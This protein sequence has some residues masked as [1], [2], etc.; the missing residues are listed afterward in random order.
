MTHPTHAILLLTLLTAC[1]SAPP[2]VLSQMGAQ[3]E[4]RAERELVWVGT[5]TSYVHD[6]GVWRRTPAQDYTFLVHQRRVGARW[7]SLK[8]QNRHRPGYD[9][10]AGPP[11]QQHMFVLEYAPPV[12]GARA[13]RVRS[14]YGDGQGTTDTT[15][16]RATLEFRARDVSRFAPYNWFRITQHYDYAK[17]TLRERVELFYREEDGTERPFARIEER[18]RFFEAR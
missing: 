6:D 18:A 9:G 10:L 15:F 5:G 3:P 13:I 12:S 8:V 2:S 4:V 11:D 1:G 17:G 16:E 7:E 14:T